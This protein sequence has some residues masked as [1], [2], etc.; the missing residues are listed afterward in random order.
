MNGNASA[1]GIKNHHHTIKCQCKESGKSK[2]PPYN[3]V[4]QPSSVFCMA[5]RASGCPPDVIIRAVAQ[6]NKYTK[7]AGRSDLPVNL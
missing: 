6:T 3:K 1:V 2:P 5:N 4:R 7:S